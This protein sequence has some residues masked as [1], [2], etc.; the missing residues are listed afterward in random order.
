MTVI[1]AEIINHKARQCF[2]AVETDVSG[3][4]AFN[5]AVDLC[6]GEVPIKYH[7]RCRYIYCRVWPSGGV[8]ADLNNAVGIDINEQ[9]RLDYRLSALCRE[10]RDSGTNKQPLIPALLACCY[11]TVQAIHDRT[12]LRQQPA[13]IQEEQV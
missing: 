7:R 12:I 8:S 2:A 5:H 13:T 4:H 11:Q 1:P 10:I 9:D 3:T 6:F